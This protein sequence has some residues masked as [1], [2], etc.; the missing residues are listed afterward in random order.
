[1]TPKE[2]AALQVR[3]PTCKAKPGAWC[4]YAPIRKTVYGTLASNDPRKHARVGQPTQKLHS[5]RFNKSWQAQRR[6]RRE[7][8]DPYQAERNALGLL[9]RQEHQELKTWLR[10]YGHVFWNAQRE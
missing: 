6:T 2:E 10:R 9:A 7:P 3:C 8:P 1:M 4:V 5:E